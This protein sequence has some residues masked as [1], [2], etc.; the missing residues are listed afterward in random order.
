[1]KLSDPNSARTAR[2]NAGR[3]LLVSPRFATSSFLYRSRKSPK[4]IVVASTLAALPAGS[5]SP[6]RIAPRI[7][8]RTSIASLRVSTR[9]PTP[10]QFAKLT[11]R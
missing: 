2:K 6:L 4:D 1:M 8:A 5:N 7:A 3:P 9:F 11:R 10:A